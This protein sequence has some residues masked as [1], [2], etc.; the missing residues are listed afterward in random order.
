[1][2]GLIWEPGAF[3]S[4]FFLTVVL[5]GAGAV[6]TGRAIAQTW[7]PL[8]MALIYAVPLAAFARFLNFA[9]FDGTLSSLW[10]FAVSYAIVAGFTFVGFRMARATQMARQYSWLNEPS[11][12][13]G[14]KARK[15]A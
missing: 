12:P 7:R 8:S 3:W 6:A 14:W 15:G 1:M 11:G 9:L 13:F 5:G 2:S 4:F 10:H